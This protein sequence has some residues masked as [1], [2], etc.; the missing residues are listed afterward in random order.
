M[1]HK[2]S[3]SVNMLDLYFYQ[4]F[5][6]Y[7]AMPRHSAIM[8]TNGNDMITRYACRTNYRL[9]EGGMCMPMDNILGHMRSLTKT[10]K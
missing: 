5:F 8:K 4:N 3:I 1:I 7:P 2:V 10:L 9:Y 6:N